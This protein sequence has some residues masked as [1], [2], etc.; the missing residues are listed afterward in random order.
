M[1]T[2]NVQQGPV[3]ILENY[4]GHRDTAV[5]RLRLQAGLNAYNQRIHDGGTVSDMFDTH[6]GNTYINNTARNYT[7]TANV[8]FD[9]NGI[10]GITGEIG[11]NPYA[12]SNFTVGTSSS[13]TTTLTST[14]TLK[15]EGA[16][17]IIASGGTENSIQINGG[18]IIRLKAGDIVTYIGS[19]AIEVA[20]SAKDLMKSKIRK[21]LFVK[22]KSRANIIK[23]V[24]EN[25]MVAIETLREYISESEFR[26]Y[27]K[28]GFVLVQG[29]SGDVYQIFRN[30]YHTKVW[31]GGKLIEEVC[32]R[33]SQNGT[34]P[35]DNVIAFKT[36]IET[37]EEEFKKLGN[38]YN[39]RKAA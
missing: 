27:I 20:P 15:T 3:E 38:V 6:T 28:H 14:S 18:E 10:A 22:T 12:T 16:M 13:L 32:V 31:R 35:T 24:P 17:S 5:T 37:S 8:A 33:L 34:P 36:M 4:I 39:M 7:N 19:S 2:F 23:D 25:E 11:T 9:H 21:N 30:R 26:K 29:K 1:A